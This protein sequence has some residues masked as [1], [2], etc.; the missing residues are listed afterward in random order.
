MFGA[1]QQLDRMEQRNRLA[2]VTTAPYVVGTMYEEPH[3]TA[4]K[5][6][7]AAAW[8]RQPENPFAAAREVEPDHAGRQYYI[9]E[10]W[11]TDPVVIAEKDRL[12]ALLGPIAR[13]PTKEEFALEVYRKKCK[14]DSEQLAYFKFF[15]ELMGY[16]AD[17]GGAPNVNINNMVGVRIMPVP[18]AAS[19]DE[20]E[21]VAMDHAR[22]LH[23]QH[24]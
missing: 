23:A 13:V 11:L 9:S 12:V 21:R 19:D 24:G 3:A 4:L 15:A 2:K 16:T 1:S 20:W 22:A 8:L 5:K 14:S 6:L 10:N 18:L 7:F 17:K